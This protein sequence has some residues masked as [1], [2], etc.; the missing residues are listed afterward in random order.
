MQGDQLR[1]FVTGATGFVGQEVLSRLFAE[2][3]RVRILARNPRSATALACNSRF[4]AEVHQ[5]DV[6][7]PES[8]RTGL[9]NVDAVIHLVGIISEVGDN[10]F[11]NIH[12]RA[13]KNMVS[14]AREAGVSRFIHMSALGTRPNAV[15]RYH[16][17]KWAAEEAVRRSGLQFTV[18]RPSLIYGPGDHFVNLFAQ[19]MQLSPVVPL[20][21]K[22]DAKFQPVSV[23]AVAKAFVGALRQPASIG[24]TYDLCGADTLTFGQIVDAIGEAT[25]RRRWKFP[26]PAPLAK[27]QAAFLELVFPRLLRRAPPLNRDQLLMLAEDNVGNPLPANTLFCLKPEPFRAG[28]SKYLSKRSG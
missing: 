27:A 18:F 4:G 12:T 25:S 14:A 24:G 28:I 19:I 9:K 6:R 8:L 23:E 17:T 1:V 5:G 26:I 2:G 11:E 16:Q 10:T 22:P 15:S 20:V 21:G 7:N 13:T 3:H